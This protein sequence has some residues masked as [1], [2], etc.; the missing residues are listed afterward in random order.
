[1]TVSLLTTLDLRVRP[2]PRI[3]LRTR[4]EIVSLERLESSESDD[5]ELSSSPE[6]D[7]ASHCATGPRADSSSISFCGVDWYIYACDLSWKRR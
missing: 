7:E 2:P 1:M 6:L 5:E 4:R 3:A